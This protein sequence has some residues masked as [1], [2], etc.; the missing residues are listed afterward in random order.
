MNAII[1]SASHLHPMLVHFPVALILA[2][3]VTEFISLGKNTGHF[4]YEVSWFLLGIGTITAIPA[5]L[6]GMFLTGDFHGPADEVRDIHETWAVITLATALATT[7][8]SSYIRMKEL[9]FT[10]MEW[11]VAALYLATGTSLVITGYY[12]GLLAYEF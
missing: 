6:T 9:Q 12:G 4:Y 8:A 2:G 1:F 5:F 7:L 10:R 11:I 3:L